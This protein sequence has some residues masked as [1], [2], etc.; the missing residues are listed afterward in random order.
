MSLL[1]DGFGFEVN[2]LR[3]VLKKSVFRCDLF[4]YSSSFFRNRKGKTTDKNKSMDL[5]D[6]VEVLIDKI[7]RVK[8]RNNRELFLIFIINY[9][10]DGEFD[11]HR[12]YKIISHYTINVNDFNVKVVVELIKRYCLK[13]G[14]EERDVVN[15]IENFIDFFNH[16][17]KQ[18]FRFAKIDDEGLENVGLSKKFG[19]KVDDYKSLFFHA[20]DTAKSVK[21][22]D[23]DVYLFCRDN[24]RLIKDVNGPTLKSYFDDFVEKYGLKRLNRKEF[25][26]RV[27]Q[28]TGEPIAKWIDGATRKVYH[29]SAV[30]QKQFEEKERELFDELVEGKEG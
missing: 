26:K 24:W 6:R 3:V 23:N 10:V 2:V 27:K 20:I 18:P 1:F 14:F 21:E 12:I 5:I 15:E 19:L 16:I 11:K 9:L 4:H 8:Q 22:I 30:Y 28:F 25:I 7:N 17:S 13:E 29:L